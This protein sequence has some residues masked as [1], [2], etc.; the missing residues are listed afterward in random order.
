MKFFLILTVLASIKIILNILY[1]GAAIGIIYFM[2]QIV[3]QMKA[4]TPYRP[5]LKNL[6]ICGIIAFVTLVFKIFI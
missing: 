4:K 6:I 2:I 5:V 1:Y 3:K